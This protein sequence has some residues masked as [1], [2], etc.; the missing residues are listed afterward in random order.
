VLLQHEEALRSKVSKVKKNGETVLP[1]VLLQ[2]EEALRS[3]V[4]K[5]KKNG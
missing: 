1:D 5:V 4:S 3:K 2:H